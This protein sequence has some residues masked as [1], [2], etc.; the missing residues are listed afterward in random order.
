MPELPE[1]ETIRCQLEA[2]IVGARV[3]RVEVFQAR[4]WR[5]HSSA[6][7]LA[8]M[9]EGRRVAGVGRRGKA[10]Y[11]LLEG[12][13][14]TTL[15]FRLGM[16]GLVRVVPAGEAVERPPAAVLRLKGGRELRFFDPRTFG[17]LIARPGH[18]IDRMPEFARY[19]PE[20]LSEEFTLEY[21]TE[22]L[23]RRTAKLEQV[24]MNQGVVA[25]IGKIYADEICFRAGLRPGRRACGLTGPM[26]ERLWRAIRDVLAE[27]IDCRGSS[28]RD[29]SYRDIYGMP[30]RFQDRMRVYQRTGEPCRRCGSAIRRTD[31]PGGRGMHWCPSCQK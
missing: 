15:I 29:E 18:D 1:A 11:L 27:G 26:R 22:A 23:S 14:P 12:E 28:A 30:G 24:L 13:Q 5:F 19:G 3:E 7:E 2:E 9:V 21:L 17:A 6:G 20:P 10:P 4:T 25:G 31:I 8:G 16:T